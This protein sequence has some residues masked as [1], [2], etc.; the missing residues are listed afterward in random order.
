MT[1]VAVLMAC[2]N[3]R[4]LTLRC[5]EQLAL[6]DVAGVVD[7]EVFLVDDGSTDGTAEAV[8]ERF[9]RVRI[10]P[11]TGD[12]FWCGGMRRAFEAAR[13]SEGERAF[14]FDWW[15]NDDTVLVPDALGRLLAAHALVE[16]R[17]TGAIVV[18]S[19]ADPDSGA[20]AY[21]GL[22][23][24][25]PLPFTRLVA[26]AAHARRCATFCGNCVLV[27]A[28]VIAKVGGLDPALRHLRGDVDYGLR[29]RALGVGSWV[30]PGLFGTCSPHPVGAWRNTRL[31]LSRRLALLYE[32]KYAWDE[33]ILVARR[34]YGPLWF[35]S[36]LSVYLFLFATHLLGKLGF[37]RPAPE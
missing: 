37:H 12:L 10:V 32:P 20:L 30:A 14:D 29:A 36:P 1:R 35:L 33:K 3:R 25:G 6:Q 15:I 7:I 8:R 34:H 4:A 26:P 9:P 16:D 31:P 28:A 24:L 27:P 5:L 2:H 23:R 21:G 11:G 22:R 19:V 13:S 18:G 17:E